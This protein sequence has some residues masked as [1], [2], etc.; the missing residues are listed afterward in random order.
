MFP[1]YENLSFKGMTIGF[2]DFTQNNMATFMA[3]EHSKEPKN[4]TLDHHY[5]KVS[6]QI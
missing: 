6:M 3:L 1:T 4:I 5:R 2:A